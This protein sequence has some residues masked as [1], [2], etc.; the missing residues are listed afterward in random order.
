MQIAGLRSSFLAFP[1]SAEAERSDRREMSPA[2]PELSQYPFGKFFRRHLADRGSLM[3]RVT[4]SNSI[5]SL[6]LPVMGSLGAQPGLNKAVIAFLDGRRLRGHV[7]DFSP[8]K[9]R[10]HLAPEDSPLQGKRSEILLK[11]LKAIFFVKDF[12]G[13]RDY[14]DSQVS[15]SPIR[16]RKIEVTFRDGETLVGTTQAYNLKNPG[17]FLFP[18]DDKSNNARIFVVSRNVQNVRTL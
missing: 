4:G 12:S 9:D 16:G 7:F 8:M 11:D 1:I 2:T 6:S 14:R 10:F 5:L 15:D 18:V 3:D 13:N 17:F